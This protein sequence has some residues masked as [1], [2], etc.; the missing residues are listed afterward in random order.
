MKPRFII[1]V[2]KV[3][4]TIGFCFLAL[5]AILLLISFV[6]NFNGKSNVFN[7]LGMPGTLKYKVMSFAY[8]GREPK[9]DYTANQAVKYSSV[10]NEYNLEVSGGTAFGYYAILIRLIHLC[11][12]MT[13]LWLFRKIFKEI[14]LERPFKDRV[15]RLLNG[16]AMLFIAADIVNM[17]DYVIFNQFIRQL[18]PATGFKLLTDIGSG[19]IIGLIIWVIAV[20]YQRGVELQ[21]QSDLTI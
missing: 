9:F 12:G 1:A 8:P 16:L 15:V 17:L 14:Q 4:A 13:I 19:L 10:V 21:T 18:A 7:D 20:I 3:V 2:F 11:L 6:C 5:F